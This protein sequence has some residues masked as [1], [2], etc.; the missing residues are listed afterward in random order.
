MGEPF[1]CRPSDWGAKKKKVFF[2]FL[3]SFFLVFTLE[4]LTKHWLSGL[5][6][7]W[8]KGDNQLG[9]AVPHS[10][11]QSRRFFSHGSVLTE[12]WPSWWLVWADV[13]FVRILRE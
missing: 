9:S 1:D 12:E 8:A 2:F 13:F 3:V 4:K 11:L 10:L 5:S 7:H 6:G